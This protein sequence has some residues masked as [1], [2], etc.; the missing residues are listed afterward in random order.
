MLAG[1]F[2]ER[3]HGVRS[4]EKSLDSMKLAVGAQTGCGVDILSW[5]L[6]KEQKQ[7]K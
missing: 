2:V 5:R 4:A 1:L 3:V 6:E 7:I